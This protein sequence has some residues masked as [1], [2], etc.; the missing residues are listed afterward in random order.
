MRFFAIAATFLLL[1]LLPA[2]ATAGEQPAV[3]VL[4][5]RNGSREILP[6]IPIRVTF[7]TAMASQSAI[8]VETDS[9]P[10]RFSPALKVKFTWRS[11]TELEFVASRIPPGQRFEL[12]LQPGLKDLEGKP[13]PATGSLGSVVGKPFSVEVQFYAERVGRRPSVPVRLSHPVRPADLAATAWLQE[14]DSRKRHPVEVVVDADVSETVDMATLTPRADLPGGATFDLI[15]DGLREAETGVALAH[16]MVEPLGTTEPLRVGKIAGFNYPMHK[17]RIAVEFNERV[18]PAEGRKIRVEPEVPNL[19]CR[20]VWNAL[21]LEG[22][23]DITK[24]YRVVVPESVTGASGFSMAAESRWTARFHPKKPALI[25]PD[26]DLHQRARLGLRFAFMQVNTGPLHWRLARVAPEKL[27]AIH[28]RLREFTAEQIDPVTSEPVVDAATGLP[29][30]VPTELLI[31]ASRLE[32]VAEGEIAASEP[33]IDTRREILWKPEHGLP[34]GAYVL[35]ITGKHPDELTLGNRA[36]ITFTEYA[37]VQK[38]FED[39]RMLHVVN[40]GTGASVPGIRVRAITAKNEPRGEAV[41]DETGMA[42]FDRQRLFPKGKEAAEWFLI[43]TPDGPMLQRVDVHRYYE[44]G[45]SDRENG[46]KPEHR[47][48]LT[49]DRP[50]YRSGQLLKFKGFARQ[51]GREL[52]IPK[53][54]EIAWKIQNRDD[55]EF[56]SGT[57]KLD[58]YGGFEGAWTLPETVQV[59]SYELVATLGRDKGKNSI[60]VQEFRPPP[61]RVELET[62]TGAKAVARITSAYFH[63]AANAGA[64]L[65]WQAT[66]T[67]ENGLGEEDVVVTDQPRLLSSPRSWI[68]TVSGEAILAADGTAE[69]RLDPPFTD[70]PAG[71]WYR[72]DWSA[73]VTAVD[74]LTVSGIATSRIHGAPIQLTLSAKQAFSQNEPLRIAIEAGANGEDEKP[75]ADVPLLIE[76]YRVS[77]KTAREQISENVSRYRNSTSFEKLASYKEQTPKAATVPGPGEY[78]VIVRHAS[79]PAIPAVSRRVY[80]AGPG[81]AEFPVQN[82]ESLGV[83]CDRPDGFYQPGDTAILS[84]QAPFAGVAWVSVEAEQVLDTLIVPLEGN[85]S[86]IELPIKPE[87]AP[88]AWATVHLLRPGG[89]QG[90]PAER[91]GS[92]QIQVRRPD[93]ELQVVPRLDLKEV[94]PR[95][96]ISGCFEIRSQGRAV[97]DADLT[98]YAVDESI[99]DAGRW[100]EPP[101]REIMYPTRQWRVS[102]YRGLERIVTGV[103]NSALHQKGF[104]IGAGGVFKGAMEVRPDELRTNFPPLAFWQTRLRSDR[105]GSVRFAFPAPDGLTK[106]RVIALAQT[107]EGQFGTGSDW[108]A[109]SKPVQVEPALPRFLR[110]G[111]EVELRAIVRQK[112]TDELPVTLRC[113]TGLTLVGGAEAT[114]TTRRGMPAVFRFKAKVGEA[115]LAAVRFETSAGAGDA[116]ELTLPIHPATLLRKQSVFGTLGEV[117]QRLPKEWAISR[118]TASVTVSSSPWLPKILGLPVLLEYPHGCMEQVSS[119]TLA[120]L[121]LNKLL[122]YLPEPRNYQRSIQQ[123]V[124]AIVESTRNGGVPYWPGGVPVPYTTVAGYWTLRDA[125][126]QGIAV[127]PQT[128]GELRASVAAIAKGG[129]QVDRFSS[130]FALFVLAA[131]S[132]EKELAPV[133]RAAYERRESFDAET[134]ALLALAMHRLGGFQAQQI[135][136]LREIN[137]PPAERSF[138]PESFS[139]TPRVDA[140]G[141]LAFASCDP[142]AES[143]ML[144]ALKTRVEQWLDS[145][146]SLS[147]QENLWLLLA[148]DTLNASAIKEAKPANFRASAPDAV[149]R[150]GASALWT[151]RDLQRIAEFIPRIEGGESLSCVIA[152]SY[153]SESPVTV[154]ADHGFR[155]ERVVKNLTDPKRT[156]EAEAPFRLGDQLQI[157]FRMI[158]PKRHHYVA[159]EG[160]LPAAFEAVNPRLATDRLPE[161]KREAAELSFAELRDRTTCLYFNRLEP[162]L[163]TSSVVVRVTTAGRFHWPATQVVPM[164]D[165]RFSGLSPSGVCHVVGD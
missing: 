154:R 144:D 38:Q 103:D 109:V 61:F 158:S 34:A 95:Q 23:F 106:Y 108:V 155:V 142:S 135:Q 67:V 126:S 123:G 79:D 40:L 39:T 58:E 44:S 56:A 134:R 105:E 26:D 24:S 64:R 4:G 140:I 131:E 147:T 60:D 150:N 129:A 11:Q 132:D 92:V 12:A 151:G 59:G 101:L 48:A 68:K 113:T 84:V 100:H 161:P 69:L 157:T 122:D 51:I 148:F 160:E 47:I 124:T 20:S 74:G 119:R 81:D 55:E 27:L 128:L 115:G 88:N 13:V 116:V 45:Y 164:Y 65:K 82:A 19:E 152:A 50:L 29:K 159:L 145:S 9:G 80:V 104:I 72:V 83:I 6:E 98:V 139:S 86:R 41:S 33:E 73:D 30:W 1:L 89:E 2:A 162:G 5:M 94:R 93:W 32:P 153:R 21:Y 163:H 70:R 136:L 125:A 76:L 43:E 133:L 22:D 149:S 46:G 54:R 10:I 120:Y 37:A 71:T 102:T 57:A 66:W 121:R 114:Q 16:L 91:F 18:S 53:A 35:E 77:T 62:P 146:E 85:S 156:G 31:E 130:V 127:P 110:A 117:S 49:S 118:G 8:D 112:V 107:K 165:S 99:L 96:Q 111:D 14:R 52:R 63:G 15:I 78:L 75:A 87:Y 137:K 7:P 3:Q 90:A 28:Q 36:L 17:R 25:F 97:A 42:R 141:A 138:D 143:P